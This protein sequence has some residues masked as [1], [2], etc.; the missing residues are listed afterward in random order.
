MLRESAQ[1]E[2]R[3][4][5]LAIFNVEF[6]PRC[7]LEDLDHK[8]YEFVAH[9]VGSVGLILHCVYAQP[10]ESARNDQPQSS[11]AKRPINAAEFE[12][13]SWPAVVVCSTDVM[14]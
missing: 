12:F 7:N 14:Q 10:E 8:I 4:K 5:R 3:S 1:E 2:L 11:A 9:Y 6:F 13:V